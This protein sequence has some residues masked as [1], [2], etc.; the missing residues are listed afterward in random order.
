[1]YLIC[2]T[3]R[4]RRVARQ[5]VSCID[6]AEVIGWVDCEGGEHVME[7]INHLSNDFKSHIVVKKEGV[8]YKPDTVRALIVSFV[9]LSLVDQLRD[10]KVINMKARSY[11]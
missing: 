2:P 7:Q 4:L 5:W 10:F 6:D 1:M 8:F 11:R 3:V 9:M